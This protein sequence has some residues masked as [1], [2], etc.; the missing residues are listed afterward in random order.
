MPRFINLSDAI[1]FQIQNE[2][3]P[4]SVSPATVVGLALNQQ[5]P[6]VDHHLSQTGVLRWGLGSAWGLDPVSGLTGPDDPNGQT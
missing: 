4:M 1:R 2:R 6:T 5:L 3:P